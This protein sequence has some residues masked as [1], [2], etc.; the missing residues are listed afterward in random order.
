MNANATST[1]T[2]PKHENQ[3]RAMMGPNGLGYEAAF[4]WLSARVPHWHAGVRGNHQSP[5]AAGW[6]V[7][8]E[9]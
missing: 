1:A 9:L 4:K 8:L 7:L 6:E 3:I 5:E 2:A